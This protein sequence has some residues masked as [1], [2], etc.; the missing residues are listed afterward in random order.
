MQ[1]ME[2]ML[3]PIVAQKWEYYLQMKHYQGKLVNLTRPNQ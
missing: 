3:M 1:E 2:D